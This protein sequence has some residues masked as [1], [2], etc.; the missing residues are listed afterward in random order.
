MARP[1][2]VVSS[3]PVADDEI[4]DE[5][6][7]D[8]EVPGDEIDEVAEEAARREGYESAAQRTDMEARASRQGWRPL[9][10]YRGKPGGWKTAKQFLDDGENYL[11]FVQKELR[12]SKQTIDRMG[13]EIEGMRTEMAST[14]ADMQKL[15]EFSRKANQAGYDRAVRD[16]KA[17]QREAVAAGDTVKYDEIEGQLGAMEDARDEAQDPPAPAP[18]GDPPPKPRAAAAVPSEYDAF[19]ADNPWF[20]SD[21]VLNAA[22]IEEHNAVIKEYPGMP[23]ADQLERAKEAVMAEFP[24]KFGRAEEPPAAPP[25]RRAAAPLP[26]SPGGRRQAPAGADPIEAIAD[27]RERADARAGYASAK[28]SVPNLTKTEFMEIFNDP[29]G[30]VLDVIARNKPRK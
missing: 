24:K 9:S 22:M 6:P 10:E 20:N 8:D 14:R 23:L 17:Q 1:G 2:S 30:D 11:P 4:D 18:A 19:I 25:P 13:N 29:H 12:E 3:L 27:Q 15:L 7:P 21:R 26:P 5:L 28:K 16:L